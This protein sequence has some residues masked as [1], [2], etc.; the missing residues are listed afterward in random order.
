MPD[1]FDHIATAKSDGTVAFAT[2]DGSPIFGVNSN[3]LGYTVA[4]ETAAQTMR[5]KLIEKYPEVM[6]TENLG[7]FPNNALHHAE[8]N[9]LLRAAAS[10]GG[11]LADKTIDVTIDRPLCERCDAVLPYL[12]VELGNPIVRFTSKSGTKIM[13]N[14]QWIK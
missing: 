13:Y 9:T 7:G 1:I 4:D 2:I 3:A 6:N 12:G 8:A 14:R 10:N 5:A 11:S